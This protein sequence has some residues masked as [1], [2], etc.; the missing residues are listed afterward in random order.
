MGVNISHTNPIVCALAYFDLKKYMLNPNLAFSHFSVNQPFS[1]D[2]T[3]CGNSNFILHLFNENPKKKS[4][5]KVRYFSKIAK[6]F[7]SDQNG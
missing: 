2:F 7:K 1:A 5:S 4:P 3:M 6:K